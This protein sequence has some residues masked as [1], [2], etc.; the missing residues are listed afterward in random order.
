M[1]DDHA[2]NGRND[3][4]EMPPVVASPGIASRAGVGARSERVL[5]YRESDDAAFR[6]WGTIGASLFVIVVL[7]AIVFA[8]SDGTVS[9]PASDRTAASGVE[10]D[11]S[12]GGANVWS[13]ANGTES[14]GAGAG[15][16]GAAPAAAVPAAPARPARPTGPVL[17]AN[18]DPLGPIEDLGSKDLALRSLATHPMVSGTLMCHGEGR[19]AH[20]F[21][22]ETSDVAGVRWR[23]KY[24]V[25]VT[26]DGYENYVTAGWEAVPDQA[27][28]DL[29]NLLVDRPNRADRAPAPSTPAPTP[30]TPAPAP[31][32]PAPSYS[33]T[34][35]PGGVGTG[36]GSGYTAFCADGTVSSSG[37][38][39]GAC[40]SHGGLL[41]NSYSRRSG[42]SPINTCGASRDGDGDG[43]G[44]E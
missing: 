5:E 14:Y 2:P 25:H 17:P 32:V 7:G 1:D 35:T 38:R 30:A 4:T 9:S 34:G 27:E 40:S 8:Q 23:D 41:S 15:G 22:V 33:G 29:A 13:G 12:A 3:T 10:A 42:G 36:A 11:A 21:C 19:R 39:Q 18:P 16:S 26:P 6:V 24:T 37:G 31:A 44:C 28:F 43:L 20:W